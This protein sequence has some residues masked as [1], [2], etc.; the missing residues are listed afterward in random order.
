MAYGRVN[1]GY[2]KP[3]ILENA[4]TNL[5]LASVS[6]G[7]Y[8]TSC[9][10]NFV[11][12]YKPLDTSQMIYIKSVNYKLNTSIKADYIVSDIDVGENNEIAISY[13]NGYIALYTYNF[14]KNISARAWI[15]NMGH[16]NEKNKIICRKGIICSLFISG[17]QVIS[18]SYKVEDGFPIEVTNTLVGYS[19]LKKITGDTDKFVMW[20][21]NKFVVFNLNGTLDY[22]SE[23]IE[24]DITDACVISKDNVIVYSKR[25]PEQFYFY[26]NGR[27]SN[28]I[29][30]GISSYFGYIKKIF[31]NNGFLYCLSG[32]DYTEKII[33][34]RIEPSTTTIPAKVSSIDSFLLEDASQN[35]TYSNVEFAS[36]GSFSRHSRLSSIAGG[37]ITLSNSI[38]YET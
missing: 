23:Q 35:V 6:D 29:N 17:M 30:N 27:E 5:S 15:K 32:S 21:N 19:N 13:S 37:R 26:R 7:T 12:F 9:N 4:Y 28:A 2:L 38:V 8:K 14:E 24:F 10:K 31:Y 18:K 11:V 25:N 3:K 36:D 22:E 16:E 33:K 20:I 1:V 34:Y